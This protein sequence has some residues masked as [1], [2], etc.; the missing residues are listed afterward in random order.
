MYMFKENDETSEYFAKIDCKDMIW[1]DAVSSDGLEIKN[2]FCFR[3]ETTSKI[4]VFCSDFAFIVNDWMRAVKCS[5]RCEQEKHRAGGKDI[6]KNIDFLVSAYKQ[7]QTGAVL[8]YCIEEFGLSYSKAQ[9]RKKSGG[10]LEKHLLFIKSCK[11][12]QDNMIHV[13][14]INPDS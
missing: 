12:S 13:K 10:E 3:I 9:M 2:R 4:N 1:T 7:K 5:I 8:N 6:V 14:N 11:D